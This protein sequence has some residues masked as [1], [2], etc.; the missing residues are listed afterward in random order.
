MVEVQEWS[1][2]RRLRFVEGLSKRE[3]ARRTGRNRRTVD[4][5]LASDQLPRYE[6]PRTPSK[7]DPFKD[8]IKR[9]LADDPKIPS[10]RIREKIE[11]LGYGGGRSI[12]DDFVR[13]VRPL[14]APERTFQKT[15][16]RPGE[17]LQFDLWRP[18]REIPVGNGQ[19]RKGYVVVCA[20]G[21]SR[22]GAGSLIFRKKAPDILA[23]LWR[24]IDRLGGVPEALVIDREASLHAGGGRPSD[25]FTAFAGS[26]ATKPVILAPRDCQ[27]KGVVERLQGYM[28]TNFEPGRSFAS[29]RDFQTQMDQ[30]FS[31]R[32]NQRIHRELRERPSARLTRETQRLRT[33]A[34]APDTDHRFVIRVPAQPYLRFDTNDYSMDPAFAGRR[35]EVR[36]GQ[37]QVSAFALTSGE[38]VASHERHFARH[39][40]ITDPVHRQALAA[41]REERMGRALSGRAKDVEVEARDLA[42]YDELVA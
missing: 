12:C 40:T 27:A 1:E 29:P 39:M 36:A 37:T 41:L 21:Y 24:G 23:G 25:E 18:K 22:A 28:T 16:Y 26:L 5:A 19:T 4:R 30:W 3:I 7:L 2:I 14:Y 42:R 6:R 31:M 13:S 33:P 38:L 35:V 8:E 11:E 9:L 34:Q 15:E 10:Q 20:L 17:I 32:A